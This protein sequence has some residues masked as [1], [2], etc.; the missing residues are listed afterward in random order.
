MLSV[1]LL[2]AALCAPV[3]QAAGPTNVK[4]S[5]ADAPTDWPPPVPAPFLS[6]E[7]AIKTIK[8]PPG[9]RME[10][11]ASEPLVEHP[12]AMS[13]DADGRAWVA[14]MRGYMPDVEGKGEDKPI[15]RISILEDTDGDGR[16]DKVTVFMDGL[17]LPRAI[18]PV[19]GGALV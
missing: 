5:P 15:G 7:D 11:V 10:V 17:V 16:M 1:L 19:R 9:F 2:V 12:V 18:C 8:L 3:A 13:F 6:A 14:E 4:D